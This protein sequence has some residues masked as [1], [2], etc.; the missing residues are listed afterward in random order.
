ME[1]EV[2]GRRHVM[3]GAMIEYD[4]GLKSVEDWD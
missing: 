4:V 1:F 3:F 2:G